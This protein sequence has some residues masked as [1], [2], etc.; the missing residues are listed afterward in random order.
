MQW[1]IQGERLYL[2]W[3][4]NSTASGLMSDAM[5]R[6]YIHIH[7]MV[8]FHNIYVLHR[9]SPT[10]VIRILRGSLSAQITGLRPKSIY[11]IKVTKINNNN[12]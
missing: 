12:N 10:T 9:Y 11:Q 2:R 8:L 5:M 4:E 6:H 7:R 3:T 1:K